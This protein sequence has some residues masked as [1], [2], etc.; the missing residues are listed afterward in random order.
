MVAINL[1]SFVSFCKGKLGQQLPTIGGNKEFCLSNVDLSGFDY[2]NSKG[3]E[4][5][6]T[7]KRIE[8]VLDRYSK[9][10]SLTTTAYGDI[11]WNASHIL[12]L[13]KLYQ[14]ERN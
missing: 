4:R 7:I 3:N 9:T 14:E 2:I 6:H 1:D 11:T 5:H 8:M 10:N 13:I 12:A